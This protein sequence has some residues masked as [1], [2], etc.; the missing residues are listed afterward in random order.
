MCRKTCIG[1]HRQKGGA[2]APTSRDLQDQN[3]TREHTHHRT[4][5]SEKAT[6][7]PKIILELSK[8]GENQHLPGDKGVCEQKAVRVTTYGGLKWRLGLADGLC[9]VWDGM[10]GWC[11]VCRM[12]RSAPA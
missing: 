2:H 6:R 9:E 4:K 7:R 1:A 5:K 10:W 11:A 3:D 12:R 8:A